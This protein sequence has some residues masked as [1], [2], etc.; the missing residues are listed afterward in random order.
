MKLLHGADSLG[1]ITIILLAK[2]S[3]P[4]NEFNIH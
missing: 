3:P 4:C 2:N 1:N